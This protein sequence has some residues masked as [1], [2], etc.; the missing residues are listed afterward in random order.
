MRIL[1]QHPP[2]FGPQQLVGIQTKVHPDGSTA[3]ITLHATTGRVDFTVAFESMAAVQ[4]EI[5]SAS[6]L[7]LY[8]QS[9]EADGGAK[10]ISNLLATAL[11]PTH[12][13]VTID[14]TTGDRLFVMHFA[15]RIPI[16]I[17]RT[18][19]QV[20]ET[21]TELEAEARRVSN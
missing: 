7:M 1:G 13:D 15:D 10:A 20:L 14:A 5:R 4:A 11:Q 9:M 2:G 18:P 21:L 6:L 19:Q 8:R 17:R 3:D 12:T 16:V